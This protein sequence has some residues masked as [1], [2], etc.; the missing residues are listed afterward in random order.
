M[1]SVGL[2]LAIG[3]CGGLGATTHFT[4][5]DWQFWAI[6]MPASGFTGMGIGSV[7]NRD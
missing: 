7:F 6:I 3:L 2:L 1:K 4:A 5:F